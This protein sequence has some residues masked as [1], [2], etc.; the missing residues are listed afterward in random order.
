MPGGVRSHFVSSPFCARAFYLMPP[1]GRGVTPVKLRRTPV[2]A[3]V[4]EKKKEY[5]LCTVFH[6]S[7]EV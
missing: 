2:K 6:G 7:T 5:L 3:E 4:K 1:K